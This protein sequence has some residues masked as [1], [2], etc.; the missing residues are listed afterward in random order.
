MYPLLLNVIGIYSKQNNLALTDKLKWLLTNIKKN[1][2]QSNNNK[3]Q[4]PKTTKK[5]LFCFCAFEI[6]REKKLKD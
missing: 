4:T 1:P 5:D 3:T 6:P 2:P